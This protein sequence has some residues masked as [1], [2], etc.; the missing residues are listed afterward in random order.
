MAT[1]K[2]TFGL[3][4]I[5]NKTSINN[6][7]SYMGI[8]DPVQNDEKVDVGLKGPPSVNHSPTNNDYD[9]LSDIV[10]CDEWFDQ[11]IQSI[12]PKFISHINE[13]NNCRLNILKCGSFNVNLNSSNQNLEKSEIEKTLHVPD[14][15]NSCQDYTSEPDITKINGEINRQIV[16]SDIC[17]DYYKFDDTFVQQISNQKPIPNISNNI[18]SDNKLCNP[19]IERKRDQLKRAFEYRRDTQVSL[20]W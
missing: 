7:Q 3:D 18:S 1:K 4:T 10:D 6:K 5:V 13:A 11:V 17:N 20:F 12:N 16:S 9:P 15:Q 2:L 14:K 8:N 19:L